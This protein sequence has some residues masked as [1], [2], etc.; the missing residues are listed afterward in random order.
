MRIQYLSDLHFEFHKDAGASFVAS[1]DPAGVDVLVVA[2]DLAVGSGIGPALDVICERY[3]SSTVLYVHGNHEFYGTTREEVVAITRA[4]CARHA[5]LHW[6]DATATEVGGRTFLGAPMWFRHPG[7][8]EK[9]KFGMN[10]F[11]QI[12]DFERW[13]YAE[14]ARALSFFEAEMRPGDIVVT[15]HLPARACVLP[16]WQ[17]HPL[18]PFFLCDVERLILERRPALWIHGHTHDTID[19]TLD[20]TRIVCNPFGYVRIEENA[21]FDERATIDL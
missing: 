4:A 9:Y 19:A 6:L 5:H 15:H 3:G 17:G 21:T 14:N 8:A 11:R 10:D 13:V 7:A 20:G 12:H 16:Q 18:N 2:G 1:L